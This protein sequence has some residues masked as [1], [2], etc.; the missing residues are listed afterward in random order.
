MKVL[1][2]SPNGA[3][4]VECEDEWDE[5][6]FYANQAPQ[7]ILRSHPQTASQSPQQPEQGEPLQPEEP[8]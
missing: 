5:A 8:S 2:T 1:W 3:R 6:D 4:L 7:T